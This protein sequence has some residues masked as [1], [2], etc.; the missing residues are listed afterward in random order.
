M[1]VI[2]VRP[3]KR[4]VKNATYKVA[5]FQNQNTKGYSYF[6]STIKIYLTEDNI[7]T[8]PLNSFKP[9]VG[10]T[11]QQIIYISPEYRLLLEERDQ[12][13]IDKDLKGGDYV[14][15]TNDGL[16]TLVKGRKYKVKDVRVIETKSSFGVVTWTDIKIKL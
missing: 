12:I 2:C 9:T 10:D 13:K 6:R 16:K 5:S 8:F 7:Q 14:V 4:L 3:T 11:F 15:P 1:N